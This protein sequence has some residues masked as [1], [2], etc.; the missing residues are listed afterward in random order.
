[1]STY[2]VQII[3]KHTRERQT[4]LLYDGIKPEEIEKVLQA[5]LAIEG[6]IVGLIDEKSVYYPFSMLC[7][8]P[9]IFHGRGF[10]LIEEPTKSQQ[11]APQP[12][13]LS[14]AEEQ[15]LVVTD[16]NAE[17]AFNILDKN[18]DGY[19]HKEEIVEVLTVAYNKFMET[20]AR[21][22]FAYSCLTARDVATATA[23]ALLSSVQTVDGD[24][25]L[26][27]DDFCAWYLSVGANPLRE[28]MVMAIE[29]MSTT[30][31]I[32]G[33]MS[34]KTARKTKVRAVRSLEGAYD[35]ERVRQFVEQCQSLLLLSTSS[36]SY[37]VDLIAVS[38]KGRS[39]ITHDLYTKIFYVYMLQHNHQLTEADEAIVR[40]LDTI[41]DI[42]STDAV[43]RIALL[44]LGSLLC[45][46]TNGKYLQSLKTLYD[47]YPD[48]HTGFVSEN[49]LTNHVTQIMRV[50]FY[51]NPDISQATGCFP[52]DLGSALATKIFLLVDAKRACKGKLSFDEFAE[53]FLHALMLGLNML[54]I[55]G[56][57]FYDYLER[58]M[59]YIGS[60]ARSGRAR[61]NGINGAR[62]ALGPSEEE[63]EDVESYGDDDEGQQVDSDASSTGSENGTSTSSE[64]RGG[65]ADTEAA[66]GRLA[67]VAD[68]T[69]DDTTMRSGG[70]G[71]A[72]DANDDGD[73]DEDGEDGLDGVQ[74][75]DS[76]VAASEVCYEGAAISVLDARQILGLTEYSSKVLCFFI[77]QE[78]A[79]L[80]GQLDQELLFRGLSK[81]IG[82]RYVSASVLTRS[83]IDFI[84]SRLFAVF[85]PDNAGRCSAV[86]LGCGL[87]LFCGDDAA[88]RSRVAWEL[89]ESD[90]A[91]GNPLDYEAVVRA[92][93]AVIKAQVCL[94]PEIDL[95]AVLSAIEVRANLEAI[96][97]FPAQQLDRMVLNSAPDFED[98]FTN[99]LYMCQAEVMDLELERYRSVPVHRPTG[100]PTALRA[101]SK[102]KSEGSYEKGM[103]AGITSDE[104]DFADYGM[105]ASDPELDSSSDEDGR[106]AH[107]GSKRNV[108]NS[109]GH[110]LTLAT[111][112][113]DKDEDDEEEANVFTNDA[114]FPPSA[115]VLELR[116]ARAV[117]GLENCSADDMM[118]TLAEYSPGG[119]LTESGWLKW[120]NQLTIKAATPEQDLSIAISLSN[121]LFEAFDCNGSDGSP[122]KGGPREAQV[123]YERIAAGLAFLCGGSPLEERLMVAFT[124]MDADSDGLI[125]PTELL[126]IVH[127]ALIAI[128]VCSRM[129][130]DKV[131]LLGASLSELAEAAAIEAISALNVDDTAAY[132]TLE[133][134]SDMSD[135]F[136]K[137]TAL[138]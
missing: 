85:D 42:L 100:S 24:N 57:F 8:S 89:L 39:Y 126:E 132:I 17:K 86:E 128:S 101:S 106:G 9:K 119:Y 94:D 20:S 46:V 109:S 111:F 49:I 15:D 105:V 14:E 36:L 27:F 131:I 77:L 79:D 133:M 55:R 90:V 75:E 114:L 28:L 112:S 70:D 16:E 130:A 21:Y 127:S 33:A 52:E 129:V 54:Q 32:F 102:D 81:L 31:D 92:V 12:A 103:R 22:S 3:G 113:F 30:A 2:Q 122:I 99:V 61:A 97:H 121:R 37:L 137:L 64:T 34:P 124:V 138:F 116:A 80:R 108:F 82:D 60:A 107:N 38:A 23:D 134:L 95:E 88:A 83:K 7:K 29:S 48:S 45:T 117:L 71:T 136:L 115:V 66:T 63:G 65:D 18:G 4:V 41:F 74:L 78:W 72:S 44:E 59:S 67:S 93:A 104:A 58:L 25:C 47:M 135:D 43:D 96:A 56:G 84:L 125:T 73:E 69:L 118:A 51:F 50:I 6:Q 98:L 19:L 5:S 76:Q 91:H 40:V 120:H 68:D 123:R 110:S 26:D 11:S 35:D 10:A 13:S 53:C 62:A 1:M 87:L